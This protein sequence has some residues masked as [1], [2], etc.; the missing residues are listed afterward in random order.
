MNAVEIEEA[1]SKLVEQAYDAAE[2]P[3]AFLEAFGNKAATIKRLRSSGKNTT[4]KSDLTGDGV[5]AVLQRNNIHIATL[6]PVAEVAK[7]F[8]PDA[9]ADLLAKLTESP[10][11]AKHKAK[12]ALATD[13]GTV[14]AASLNSDEPP[15]VCEYEKLDDHFGTSSNWPESRPFGR[16]AKMPSTSKRPDG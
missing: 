2:F 11:T 12:F 6:N 9:V 8:G 16:F 1:V 14:H 15:L 3:F 4:N 13:G 10:A 7:T 5:V